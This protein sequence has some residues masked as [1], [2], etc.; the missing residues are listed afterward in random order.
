MSDF[1]LYSGNS[2]TNL[3]NYAFLVQRAIN[4]LHYWESRTPDNGSNVKINRI[5]N[6]LF[7]NLKKYSKHPSAQGA[8]LD[9]KSILDNL[10]VDTSLLY[11]FE[12]N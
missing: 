10:F 6:R 5:K 3:P 1:A 12:D 7:H 11:E 2:D 8:L 9:N 4:Q